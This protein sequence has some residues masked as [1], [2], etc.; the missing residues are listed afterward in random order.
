MFDALTAPFRWLLR[1]AIFLISPSYS[2]AL[3]EEP[4]KIIRRLIG[5]CLDELGLPNPHT[6]QWRIQFYELLDHKLEELYRQNRRE[7]RLLTMLTVT[8][9]FGIKD[10]LWAHCYL[11][12]AGCRYTKQVLQSLS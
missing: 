10:A 7:S 5:Q 11:E 9:G 12:E 3:M 2:Q 4:E 8:W 6:E 1:I